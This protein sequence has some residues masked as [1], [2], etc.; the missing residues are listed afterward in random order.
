M[1]I[2]GTN[3]PVYSLAYPTFRPLYFIQEIFP[4]F[5]KTSMKQIK[6]VSLAILM[7]ASVAAAQ[8]RLL[9]IDDIFSL[10]SKVRVNFSGTPTRLAWSS[11]GKSFR[12]A[13]NGGLVRVKAVSGDTT[14]Y[15]DAAKFRAALE[16]AGITSDEANRI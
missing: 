3:S 10:D 4:L 7:F 2:N 11:D 16:K 5:I 6:L 9:T 13:R 1:S 8:D 15:Y 14:P 12:Q